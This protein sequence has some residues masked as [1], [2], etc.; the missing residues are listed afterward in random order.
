MKCKVVRQHL[1]AS[2]KPARP[3]AVMAEHLAQ[4]AGCRAFQRRL[5]NMERLVSELPVPASTAKADYLQAV[6]HSDPYARHE[7]PEVPWRQ[8]ERALRKVAMTFAMAAGLLFFALVWYAW[9][10]HQNE[11]A[12]LGGSPA[13]ENRLEDVVNF[14]D[15]GALLAA[16]PRERF[17]RLTVIAQ[18]LHDKAKE[19]ALD[20]NFSEV[21]KLSAQYK[22]LLEE[23]ILADAPKVPA[24]D[25]KELLGSVAEQFSRDASL[26]NQ[27]ATQHPLMAKPLDDMAI[28]ANNARSKL[29]ELAGI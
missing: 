10:R 11:V 24:A 29:R 19:R 21:S 20:E 23:G 22:I 18:K 14:Y 3:S 15:R 16:H 4:C 8:R 9:Q 27:L 17:E 1:L 26:A 7:A 25:R 2:A 5:V 12:D 28:V 6:L 13:R